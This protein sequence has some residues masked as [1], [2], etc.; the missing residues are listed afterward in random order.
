[1]IYGVYPD[2]NSPLREKEPFKFTDSLDIIR[3]E[4]DG[5]SLWGSSGR[6]LAEDILQG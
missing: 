4:Q 2:P 1:M 3:S 6:A 5:F